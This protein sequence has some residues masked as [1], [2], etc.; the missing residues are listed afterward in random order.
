MSADLTKAPPE[1]Q[2]LRGD[3]RLP[4]VRCVTAFALAFAAAC[5][6]PSAHPPHGPQPPPAKLAGLPVG[7]PLVTPGEHMQYKLA[8]QGV[9]LA[10][11]E[12]G[13]GEVTQVAGKPAILVQSHAKTVGLGALVKVDDYFSSWIDVAT[14]RPLKW[15]CD[16]Y[17]ND[18][19]HK[20]KTDADLA[21]RTGDQVPMTF[22]LDD[23]P[24]QPEPQKVSM[25]DVWDLNALVIALRAWEDVAGSSVA[26]E[27]LR[28]R[29]LWHLD[30][31]IHGKE[32]LVTDLEGGTELPALRFDAK[33]YKLDRSGAR[34]VGS[35]ERAF[36]IWISDD[37]GRVPLKIV[38]RTDY[39]DIE[40][41]IVDYQPG[42]GQRLRK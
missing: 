3:G 16:E 26:V 2:V 17:S 6:S 7:P 28:S 4:P 21:G 38:A 11:Y 20:E 10:M 12:M 42:T 36:S 29:Y 14:G 30:T 27:A 25:P 33:L 5:S 19:K 22:H 8:L 40:M 24:P 34:A 9:E 35:D 37:D 15:A 32:K 31:T 41:K 13:V 39:G 18:G 23:D 1:T